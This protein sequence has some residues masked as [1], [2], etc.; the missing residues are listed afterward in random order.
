MRTPYLKI[1]IVIVITQTRRVLTYYGQLEVTSGCVRQGYY[2]KITPIS[3]IE[4]GPLY[5]K[6][7]IGGELRVRVT[8]IYGTMKLSSRTYSINGVSV[9]R[10]LM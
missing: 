5:I 6:I 9:A 7:V 8:N 2:Q 10:K 1:T 4:K 3:S